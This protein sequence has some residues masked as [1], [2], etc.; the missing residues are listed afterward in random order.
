MVQQPMY[1]PIPFPMYMPQPSHHDSFYCRTINKRSSSTHPNRNKSN[2][3]RWRKVGNCILF[4]LYLK[5]FCNLVQLNRKLAFEKFMN[6]IKPHLF[7]IKKL[8]T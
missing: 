1:L 5:R 7:S 6:N 2:L 3:R 8:I 4:Y